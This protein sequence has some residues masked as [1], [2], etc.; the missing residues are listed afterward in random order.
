[1][2]GQQK[3][4]GVVH[5]YIVCMPEIR[6]TSAFHLE[7]AVNVLIDIIVVGGSMGKKN[8]Q[9]KKVLK[10]PESKENVKSISRNGKGGY[11]KSR[12][13]SN[14]NGV[15]IDGADDFSFRQSVEG[16]SHALCSVVKSRDENSLSLL[17]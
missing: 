10:K 13:D 6:R 4:G 17:Q 2:T 3:S 1:M 12:K 7:S 9:S 8:T 15:A 11:G 5:L 16:L 14:R